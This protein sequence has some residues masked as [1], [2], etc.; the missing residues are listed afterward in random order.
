MPGAEL[1]VY[2][3]LSSP[4]GWQR[5]NP[6]TEHEEERAVVES[7]SAMVGPGG[8]DRWPETNKQA[9]SISIA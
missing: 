2:W 1:P 4:E 7:F 9:I 8:S 3:P 6:E 5:L